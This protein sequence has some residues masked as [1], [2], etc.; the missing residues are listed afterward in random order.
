MSF[1][2]IHY[3]F[4]SCHSASISLLHFPQHQKPSFSFNSIYHNSLHLHFIHCAFFSYRHV[5]I[6]QLTFTPSPSLSP[7]E[8]FF[9]CSLSLPLSFLQYPLCSLPAGNMLALGQALGLAAPV[10]GRWVFQPRWIN[11]GDE[12]MTSAMPGLY[13]YTDATKIVNAVD[14]IFS[15]VL[16]CADECKADP[17]QSL[18]LIPSQRLA[19][20]TLQDS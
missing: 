4:S 16:I 18:K 3:I 17:S 11:G 1:V 20:Y 14:K 7:L 13:G 5:S 9:I 15:V 8:P 12:A 10:L 2:S 6:F 19:T